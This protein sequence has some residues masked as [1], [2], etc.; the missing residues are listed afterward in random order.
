MFVNMIPSGKGLVLASKSDPSLATV[1]ERISH[2][3][4]DDH[5]RRL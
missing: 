3:A 5:Q 2:V 1:N 4:K